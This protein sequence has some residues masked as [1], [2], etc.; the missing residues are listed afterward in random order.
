MLAV[1][2]APGRFQLWDV[3][4]SQPVLRF[5]EHNVNY[6]GWDFRDG[7]GLLGLAHADGGISIYDTATS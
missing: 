7:G 5:E 3:S 4:D 6:R 2:A 1:A